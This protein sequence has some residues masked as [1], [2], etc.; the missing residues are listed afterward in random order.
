MQGSRGCLYPARQAASHS[1]FRWLRRQG[2]VSAR[3]EGYRYSARQGGLRRHLPRDL[4]RCRV[5]ALE[6][7]LS[8]VVGL[9]RLQIPAAA[10]GCLESQGVEK[11]AGLRPVVA[12]AHHFP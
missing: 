7:L 9:G 2:L 8:P 4:H 10:L 6:N 1:R 11:A 12:R 5:A 3:P